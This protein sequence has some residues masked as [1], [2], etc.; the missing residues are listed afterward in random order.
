MAS[1]NLTIDY[2]TV[3]HLSRDLIDDGFTL[4][5]TVAYAGLTA[6]ALGREVGIVTSFND[7][8]NKNPLKTIQVFNLPAD[9][10]T[11]FENTYQQDVRR[12][13]IHARSLDLGPAAIPLLWRSANLVHLGPIANEVDVQLVHHFENAFIGITP[14]GWM[15]K[16]DDEG[17]ISF[18]GWEAI[19]EI[20][21]VVHAVV[22][23]IEDINGDEAIAKKLAQRCRMLALTKGAEGV[24]LYHGGKT[25][26]ILPPKVEEIDSTGSG[27]IF[28]AAFFIYLQEGGNPLRAARFANFI[29]SKSVSKSG[30]E[31]V[32]DPSE[33]A[34]IRDNISL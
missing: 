8:L 9:T 1:P 23:S 7:S 34:V 5:G 20:L 4:G 31:S 26:S 16:W 28:A 21:P 27:D 25:T 19:S 33:I 17:V 22:I 6:K 30:L 24:T 3:G 18:A 32:P 13:I 11:T 2:L 12:Q 14:Q 15:R 10:T 29:A